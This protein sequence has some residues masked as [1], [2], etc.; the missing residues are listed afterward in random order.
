MICPKCGATGSDI[1]VAVNT[2]ATTIQCW[3]AKCSWGFVQDCPDS[4]KPYP[5][6]MPIRDGVPVVSEIPDITP[7]DDEIADDD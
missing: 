6:D 3:C 4:L 5:V 2:F 1:T 7:V